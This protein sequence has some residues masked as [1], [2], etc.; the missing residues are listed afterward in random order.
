MVSMF[1]LCM[2][3]FMKNI[4][5]I[6][7]RSLKTRR[8]DLLQQTHALPYLH[9]NWCTLLE[10]TQQSYWYLNSFW[11]VKTCI[12]CI[13]SLRLPDQLFYI[14]GWGKEQRLIDWWEWSNMNFR[15]KTFNGL[16]FLI[17]EFLREFH[18][19]ILKNALNSISCI[20]YSRKAWAQTQGFQSQVDIILTN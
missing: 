11:S 19:D 15:A 10:M 4:R 14:F 8:S 20:H 6:T 1:C 7:S 18:T 17:L 5:G 12:W 3:G 13:C 16:I 9:F 2:T